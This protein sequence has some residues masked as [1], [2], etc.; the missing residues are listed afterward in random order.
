MKYTLH[1]P[2]QDFKRKLIELKNEGYDICY[3]SSLSVDNLKMKVDLWQN[4]VSNYF[5]ESMNCKAEE[6]IDRI[7]YVPVAIDFAYWGMNVKEEKVLLQQLNIELKN[8]DYLTDLFSLIETFENS[9][10]TAEHIQTV[11]EK[12]DFILGK[13]NTVFNDKYF[14]VGDILKFNNISYRDGEPEEISE[15]LQKKGYIIRENNYNGDKVKIS[16][17]GAAFIER[18][19]KSTTKKKSELDEMNEKIDFIIEK[20]T[21]L[22]YGQNII[23]DE[24]DELRNLYSKLPKK[25]WKQ[26]LKG[27]LMDLALNKLISKETVVYVYKTLTDEILKLN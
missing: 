1:I 7:K 23:F 13:L 25:T 20:L 22:G 6:F 26:V 24:F 5:L 18:K 4:K 19:Q 14:S 15:L 21:E 27:K 2:Y 16:I 17:K 8:L 10:W 9:A 3:D 12:L 11:Q